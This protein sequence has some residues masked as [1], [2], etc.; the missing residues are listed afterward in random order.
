MK[1]SLNVLLLLFIITPSLIAPIYADSSLGLVASTN[2][3]SYQPGDKV[4]I[5]GSVPQI[6]NNNPVTIIVRNPMGNVYDVGQVK[7]LNNLFVHDFVINDDSLGGT[8][9]VNIKYGTFSDQLHFVLNAGVLTTIPIYD[10]QIKIRTNGTN[11]IKYGDVS[12][13]AVDK[14]VSINM[15]TTDMVGNSAYQQYQIPKQVIDTPG[16]NIIVKID[17]NQILCPQS[18]TNTMRILDCTIPS[19]SKEIEFVGTIVIPEFGPLVGITIIVAIA[20]IIILPRI[21]KTHF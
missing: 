12:V 11:Q 18:E 4:T 6:I 9:T 19:D 16:G 21:V 10:S 20:S 15:D 13:S 1:I 7:L 14:T 8:Y 5:S 2:K 17:G 3:D